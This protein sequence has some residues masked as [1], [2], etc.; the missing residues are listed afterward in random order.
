MKLATKNNIIIMLF[1]FVLVASALV[2]Y[3]HVL[4][5]DFSSHKYSYDGRCGDQ[6][7]GVI[8]ENLQ[9]IRPSDRH[10]ITFEE[11]EIL[12]H[13][14]DYL[15]DIMEFFQI[16]VYGKEPSRLASYFQKSA[17]YVDIY[18][19]SLAKLMPPEM[20]GWDMEYHNLTM[21]VFDSLGD[22]DGDGISEIVVGTADIRCAESRRDYLILSAGANFKRMSSITKLRLDDFA[23]RL[24]SPAWK[25][26][27]EEPV[28]H[29]VG[30][31]SNEKYWLF[32][33]R[34][35][36][37]PLRFSSSQGSIVNV[38]DFSDD[39]EIPDNS[40]ISGDELW[41]LNDSKDKVIRFNT[42]TRSQESV[43][44]PAEIQPTN[45]IH[46]VPYDAFDSNENI[47]IVSEKHV[48]IFDADRK[49]IL[50]KLSRNP[51][52]PGELNVGSYGDYDQDGLSDFW[53]SSPYYE[54]SQG[55]VIGQAILISGA[56]LKALSPNDQDEGIYSIADTRLVGSPYVPSRAK[57]GIGYD[58]SLDGGD[59]DGDGLLDFVT[60]AHYTF[61]NSGSLYI[62]PGYIMA[63][64]AIH[65]VEDADVV[66]LIGAPLSYLGTGVQAGS[67]WNR[68]GYSDIVVGADVDHE[69]GFGAGAVYLISG[70]RLMQLYTA[71]H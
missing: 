28:I 34:L 4:G 49:I 32:N 25:V 11:V 66:R 35:F 22:L 56:K 60:V 48:S 17:S 53:I 12:A 10:K 23:I 18:D 16:N 50:I 52:L 71:A 41:Y 30:R 2:F 26:L 24:T 68:D 6:I 54:D 44:I 14:K 67:D 13:Y 8:S 70:K 69:A 39:L 33:G 9:L 43:A 58:I 42:H 36:E 37:M 19:A 38:D 59:H 46:Y 31:R 27:G 40:F 29:H 65:T 20:Q 21:G 57:S 3:Y 64:K 51:E 45:S 63:S 61:D 1:I 55:N 47:L 7:I 62:L 5:K 15:L